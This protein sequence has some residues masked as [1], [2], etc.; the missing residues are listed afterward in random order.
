ML[1][2]R[3]KYI[4]TYAI[5]F[6]LLIFLLKWIQWKFL[7]S[8][9]SFEIYIALIA[10]FFTGLGVWIASQLESTVNLR[11]KSILP[12]PKNEEIIRQLQLSQR[13]YEVLELLAQGHRNA[14]IAEHLFI[15]VST[16][17]THVSN[18]LIKLDVANRTQALNK[19]RSLGLLP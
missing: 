1:S 18:L 10:L 5:A 16:V 19:A 8:N 12:A 6:A 15:S 13:E 4:A 17:K 9:H 2:P 14:D 3:V 7:I 11:L